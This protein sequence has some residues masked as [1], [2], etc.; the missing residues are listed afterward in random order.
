[1]LASREEPRLVVRNVVEV[2]PQ[3]QIDN[4]IYWANAFNSPTEFWRNNTRFLR[5]TLRYTV[6]RVRGGVGRALGL[7][8]GATHIAG[9]WLRLRMMLYCL[10]SLLAN[11]HALGDRVTG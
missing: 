8:L 2:L 11:W 6:L 7:H 9:V 4:I 3:D 5:D 1:L 10:L